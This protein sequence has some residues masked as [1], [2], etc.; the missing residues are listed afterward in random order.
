MEIA[1]KP[2][3]PPGI[4]AS[5]GGANGLAI[6]MGKRDSFGKSFTP[7]SSLK[8]QLHTLIEEEEE[9]EEV[10]ESFSSEASEES[11]PTVATSPALAGRPRPAALN[12]KS[13]TSTPT[14]AG[15]PT[16]SLTP[17]PRSSRLRPLTLTPSPTPSHAN[18][19][20]IKNVT[21]VTKRQS[22]TTPPMSDFSRWPSPS[23]SDSP[24]SDIASRPKRASI[25]YKSGD[26]P[27]QAP[28]MLPTP[29]TT[30]TSLTRRMSMQSHS[31]EGSR[32]SSVEAGFAPGRPLSVSEQHFL[33]KSHNA[34]L[35]RIEDLERSLRSQSRASRR[36]STLS[37]A[38]SSHSS[39]TSDEMLSFIADLKAER[40]ELKGD[41]DGWRT[42]VA[43][44]EKQV[45]A[46]ARHIEA[47]RRD[48]WVARERA[49]QLEAEKAVADKALAKERAER[50]DAQDQLDAARSQRAALEAELIAQADAKA[51]LEGEADALRVQ[52]ADERRRRE[53]AERELEVAGLLATPTAAFDVHV[54][55][56][57]P[58][59]S[60]SRNRGLGFQSIDSQAT[61]VESV[62]GGLDSFRLKAVAEEDEDEDEDELL[63]Y[64]DED[65]TDLSYESPD[66]ASSSLEEDDFMR[67]AASGSIT[68]EDA[69]IMN[70]HSSGSTDSFEEDEDLVLTPVLG[71]VAGHTSVG[72]RTPSPLEFA[73]THAPRHSLSKAWTFPRGAAPAPKPRRV[74]PVDRFFACLEDADT[75]SARDPLAMTEER[76]KSLFC[77]LANEEDE[78]P[79]FFLPSH[80]GVEV[81]EERVLD[82]VLEED[83][84][85]EDEES[86]PFEDDFGGEEVEGGIRFVFTPLPVAPAPVETPV[87]AMPAPAPASSGLFFESLPEGDDDDEMEEFTFPQSRPASLSTPHKLPTAALPTP[88]PVTT[89]FKVMSPKP[90]SIPQPRA[91]AFPRIPPAPQAVKKN[92]PTF[93]PQPMRKPPGAASP[94]RATGEFKPQSRVA[95]TTSTPPLPPSSSRPTTNPTSPR[96]DDP[97]SPEPAPARPP[98]VSGAHPADPAAGPIPHTPPRPGP[99]S[100][101]LSASPS[102]MYP[103]RAFETFTNL[104]PAAFSWTARSPDSPAPTPPGAAP[105]GLVSKEQQLDKLRRRME[106]ERRRQSGWIDASVGP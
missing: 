72:A 21:N 99:L 58:A 77:Q 10:N 86:T 32:S 44:Y 89:P 66:S 82:V 7:S 39:E 37:D 56:I 3:F 67:S 68:D 75:A 71:P 53:D 8:D 14:D 74:E 98:A 96:H 29:E 27:S 28:T 104:I 17:S 42:R 12:I 26:S 91:F 1:S 48:S 100:P 78:L 16:P 5:F 22:W 30:P 49:A 20:G 24:A 94:P 102:L 31:S 101:T 2:S 34:M 45:G 47:E 51:L 25:S 93:I 52:L 70:F 63:H 105:R 62:D 36:S 87:P 81:E 60:K 13:A 80:V 6:T 50:Q 15:L 97:C 64:E 54:G 95:A 85:E 9:E 106:D 35:A 90:S 23:F 61:D 83:E 18:I 65:E 40:D 76:G 46:L 59:P 38:S 84:D 43:D 55:G 19:D 4:G 92:I 41:V 73:P 103:R 11:A 88:S 33:F 69:T 79:P 57:P